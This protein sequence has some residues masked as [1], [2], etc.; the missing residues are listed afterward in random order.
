MCLSACMCT[1]VRPGS[2]SLCFYPRQKCHKPPPCLPLLSA[3]VLIAL[4]AKQFCTFRCDSGNVSTLYNA[5]FFLTTFLLCFRLLLHLLL[6]QPTG[7]G[8]A[9]ARHSDPPTLHYTCL[10]ALLVQACLSI[11]V[12]ASKLDV[13]C[14]SQLRASEPCMNKLTIYTKCLIK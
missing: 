8:D 11:F 6:L 3:Q 9:T 13:S 12:T 7:F 2:P 1:G 4:C 5:S 10:R 14:Y